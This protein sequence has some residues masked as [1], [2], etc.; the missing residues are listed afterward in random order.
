[1]S[2]RRRGGI[3]DLAFSY[4]MMLSDI[5]EGLGSSMWRGRLD[6]ADILELLGDDEE[7]RVE[8][9]VEM[10]RQSSDEEINEFMRIGQMA[11]MR[12]SQ[13][14]AEQRAA[15]VEPTTEDDDQPS[16]PRRARRQSTLDRSRERHRASGWLL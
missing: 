4:P 6:G 8:T 10:L 14:R 13:E 2:R 3:A 15:G 1:V 11:V 16:R 5:A 7:E 9:V 12:V